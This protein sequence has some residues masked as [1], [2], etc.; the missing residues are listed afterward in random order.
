MDMLKEYGEKFGVKEIVNDFGETRRTNEHR[1][2][3]DNGLFVSI[4]RN[5]SHPEKN[6]DWSVAMCDY[7]G[8]FNWDII[9]MY[10]ADDGC[11][12]CNTELEILIACETIRRL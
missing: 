3:F 5:L 1:I 2:I 9:N 12:Y 11:F 8:F 7:N 10:G 4:V 6:A